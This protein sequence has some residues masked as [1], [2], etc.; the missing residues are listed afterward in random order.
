MF[1]GLAIEI[2]DLCWRRCFRIFLLRRV[3]LCCGVLAYL[4]FCR[5]FGLRETIGY[6]FSDILNK[7]SNQ[8]IP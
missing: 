2:G 3:A 1:V 4:L 8:T 5:V 7:T 6:S